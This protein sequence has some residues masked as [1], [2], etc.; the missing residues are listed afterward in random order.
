MTG[1]PVR[2][3]ARA[4]NSLGGRAQWWALWLTQAKFMVGVCGVLLDERGR[5]L[6]LRHRFWPAGSW[7]LPGG[8][9]R[10]GERLEDALAR[11]LREETALGLEGL[12]L[13]RVSSGYRLRIEVAFA[14]RLAGGPARLDPREVLSAE[15]F[16][17]DALPAGLL[18]GHRDLIEQAGRER[19]LP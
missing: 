9:A 17:P 11:E 19:M 6:L 18:T 1:L 5:V 7:G 15:L 16:A 4:W 8:Y 10:A 12:R 14:G 13:L 3:L 2:L